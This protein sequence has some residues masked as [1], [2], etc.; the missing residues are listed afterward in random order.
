MG[1]EAAERTEDATPRRRNKEREKGNISKSK[2]LN[3]AL[4]ITAAVAL[5]AVFGKSMI[6]NIQSMMR[7]T[8]TNINPAGFDSTNILGIMLPYF[9]YLGIIVVPF[10]VLLVIAAIIIIKPAIV[11]KNLFD[12]ST[13]SCIKDVGILA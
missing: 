11:Y 5:L 10:F 8:F 7:E 4:V 3:A 12:I 13:L 9:H 6:Q 1:N 2:D